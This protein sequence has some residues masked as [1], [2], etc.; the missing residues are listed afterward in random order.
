MFVNTHRSTCEGHRLIDMSRNNAG[1]CMLLG[2]M[3]SISFARRDTSMV[4]VASPAG[5]PVPKRASTVRIVT[6]AMSC[7]MADAGSEGKQA[8]SNKAG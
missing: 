8:G 2:C 5:R 6:A 4:S 3:L 1:I 7:D